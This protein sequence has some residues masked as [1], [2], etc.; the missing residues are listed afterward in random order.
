[1]QRLSRVR[2]FSDLSGRDL[3]YI[4]DATNVVTY[5]EGDVIINEGDSGVGFQLILEGEA[6][7]VRNGRTV[8][9]LGPDDFFGEMALIDQGPRTA[10]VIAATPMTNVA[11]ASWDFRPIVKSRPTMAWALLVH[12]AGRIRD[13]QKREDALRA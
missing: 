10:S 4:V 9:R 8:A 12:L 13:G 11:I 6:K 1:M 5:D 7:V 2:L 3:R